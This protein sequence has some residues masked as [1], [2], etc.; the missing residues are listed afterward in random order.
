MTTLFLLGREQGSASSLRSHS[1]QSRAGG[2]VYLQ[3]SVEEDPG[4][5]EGEGELGLELWTG[6]G[7]VN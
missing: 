7:D 2:R 4:L 5:E 1:S 6:G 3:H